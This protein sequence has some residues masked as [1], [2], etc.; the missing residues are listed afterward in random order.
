[1]REITSIEQISEAAMR[2]Q[3]IIETA[4]DGIITID[5]RAIVDH[6]NPAAAKLFG[7]DPTEIIGN[8]IKMLMPS[9]YREEHDGYLHN[10]HQTGKAYIIGIGREVEGLKKDGAIFPIRLAVSEMHIDGKR[11]YTGIIHDLTDV[12]AAEAKVLE[13]N[14]QLEN[15]VALRTEELAKAIDRLL[16]INRKLER[17]ITERETVENE[18][19]EREHELQQALEKE[20]EL[21]A[22][23]SRF[24]SMASHEF[25]TP[26]STIL[27]SVELVEMYQREDQQERRER[28]I[29][30]IK[31]AVG[32]LTDILNDFLSLSRLDEGR[33]E[34]QT[35]VF[36]LETFIQNIVE[37]VEHLLKTGQK[38]H[39]QGD[40]TDCHIK[41]DKRFLKNIFLNLLSNASKYSEE[42]QTIRCFCQVTDNELT[43][44]II[45]EGI[46][47]PEEDQKHLFTRFFRANNVENIK[48]TGLGLHIVR[49]Y[50]ELLNGQ[51]SFTSQLGKGS[52]FTV[53]VPITIEI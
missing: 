34:A 39:Y 6:I 37:D 25:R 10:Y 18:L 5:E 17:E 33:I 8:N 15:K 46:G 31:T 2:L 21:N 47:I 12:K 42:G 35:E 26:L 23:K 44:E 3:A 19:R 36:H 49:R 13:L 43:L 51:I 4:I 16:G 7:Y 45:D 41:L 32:N 1:V 52:A 40:N 30:R 20:K 53:T 29:G 38:L 11:M 48:G 50:A 9:P 28:H 14:R 22:L 27:S 24:V